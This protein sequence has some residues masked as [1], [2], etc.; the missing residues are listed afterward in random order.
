M[1]VRAILSRATAALLMLSVATTASAQNSPT[2][3]KKAAMIKRKA[4]TLAP[5]SAITVIPL[6]G[7]EE[8]GEFLS[9]DQEGFRFQDID[10]KTEVTLK[11]AEVRK[12]K[13]GYGGYNF[14]RG[15]HTDH[16]RAIIVTAV[17][18]GGL[19]ALIGAAAAAKN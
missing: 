16:T 17:V 6:H 13:N 9:D 8:F 12:L 15:R 14:A 7:N 10:R 18:L 19:G 11:Y 2:L 5:H 3:S 1:S 4:D